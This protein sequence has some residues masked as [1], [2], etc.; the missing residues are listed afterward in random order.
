MARNERLIAV[1]FDLED[2]LVQTPWEDR[3]RVLEFR[4]HTRRKLLELGIPPNIL[5][6]IERATIMRN[7]STEYVAE[8]FSEAETKKFQQEMNAF[9]RLYELDAAKNSKL[10]SDTIPTLEKI[11]KLGLKMGLVTNTSREAADTVFQLHG[12][13]RYFD[14]VVTR[15][16]VKKLKPDPEG[17]LLAIA[18]L[19]TK[20][21]L[22][23]GDLVHDAV[24][25]ENA[26]GVSI[27]IKR[28]TEK[29]SDFH[30]DYFVHSLSEI[31]TIVQAN[32]GKMTEKRVN[33]TL[34]VEKVDENNIQRILD[35]LR[36]DV[37]RHVF[38]LYD[39]QYAPE[40]TTAYAAFE[41]GTPKGY[42]LI[43][44]AMEYPSVIL[45]GET[46]IAK[47]L[48]EYAPKSKFIMHAHPNLLPTVKI[49]FPSA[50]H[51]VEDWMLVRK[52]EASYFH[53]ENVRKLHTEEDASSLAMLIESR[54]DH[55]AESIKRYFDWISKMPLYGVFIN[56]E[57]V[58]YAGSLVQLPQIWMIGGVYTNPK[59][60]NKGYATL[61]TSAIT[62]EALKNADTAALFV[63]SDNHPAIKAYEKIGYS[64]IGE[65]L[66]VDVG[67]GL[68]P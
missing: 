44:T 12:L 45:E 32:I 3:R 57:L 61:A 55:N 31:P 26:N 2:T 62:K 34:T 65:K 49:G 9:L 60:R 20:S 52:G 47:K 13:E 43:Y 8:N 18:K 56:S 67:T 10:F 39:I 59:H 64:K 22:M 63:R 1:L 51:Y 24:A 53:S 35:Y 4:R 29:K 17:V 68:K 50:K 25:A 19:R 48:I 16:N 21:F 54:K 58:S 27:I 14:A 66:W 28:N 46:N 6:G 36:S 37:I 5:E 11:R 33:L 38:A 30:A 7:K 41:K 23:V 42:I 15:E 40:H